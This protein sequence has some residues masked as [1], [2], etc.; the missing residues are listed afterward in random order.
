MAS[1][2]ATSNKGP[3]MKITFRQLTL[4]ASMALI[5]I[6][7][8]MWFFAQVMSNLVGNH[9]AILYLGL[10]MVGVGV[11]GLSLL[12][13]DLEKNRSHLV[14]MLLGTAMVIMSGYLLLRSTGIVR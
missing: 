10:V 1:G 2:M 9:A 12:N 13:L 8:A 14:I 7:G 6:G 3:A 5:C 11:T 4:I